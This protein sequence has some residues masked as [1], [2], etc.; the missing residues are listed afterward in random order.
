M[1]NLVEEGPMKRKIIR[2][3]CAGRE[4]RKNQNVIRMRKG[5]RP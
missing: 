5:G 2:G 1:E 4:E 3:F